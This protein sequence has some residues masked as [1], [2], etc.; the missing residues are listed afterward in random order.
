MFLGA[1]FAAC[2]KGFAEDVI[3]GVTSPALFLAQR[4]ATIFRAWALLS[5]GVSF[6]QRALPPSDWIVLRC[7]RTVRSFLTIFPYRRQR[8]SQIYRNPS[9]SFEVIKGLIVSMLI[10]LIRTALQSG[11]R[12]MRWMEEMGTSERLGPREQYGN[13]LGRK[14]S[15]M[16]PNNPKWVLL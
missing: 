12:S 16:I 7:S 4:T 13:N 14:P 1:F 5:S 6:A 9:F 10:R 3:A 2:F 15:Q 8:V 11:T